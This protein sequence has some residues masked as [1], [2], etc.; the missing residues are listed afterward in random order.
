VTGDDAGTFASNAI[1][2]ALG[3]VAAPATRTVTFKVKIAD[4]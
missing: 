4:Q 2:V 3:S 1:S